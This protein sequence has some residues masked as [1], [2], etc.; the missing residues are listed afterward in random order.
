MKPQIEFNKLTDYVLKGQPGTYWV[1]FAKNK[2]E[3]KLKKYGDSFNLVIYVDKEDDYYIIPYSV[4]KKLFEVKYLYPDKFS[5]SEAW[6]VTIRNHSFRITP[7]KNKVNVSEFY[8]NP[9]LINDYNQCE[10][11]NAFEIENLKREINARIR[12]SKFRKGVLDNFNNTCCISGIKECELLVASHIIP[13][14]DK[15]ETRLDPTNGLCLSILY[16]KLFDKGYFTINDNLEIQIIKNDFSDLSEPL[17]QILRFIDGQK[18]STLVKAIK[19][20][21]LKYHRENI[22]IDG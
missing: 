11:N 8:A 17:K 16:D 13:W 14:A 21:Y 5:N 4:V 9:H 19:T 22:F 3:E 1:Q 10:E 7:S 20:E 15:K 2:L 18:I 12:Q 6:K